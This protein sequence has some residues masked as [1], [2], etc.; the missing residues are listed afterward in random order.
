MSYLIRI[1]DITAVHYHNGKSSEVL[2]F[3][4]NEGPLS[5]VIVPEKGEAL[6]KRLKR[7]IER[8]MKSYELFQH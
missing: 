7:A 6:Q 2:L 1:G 8:V 4:E 5:R 3:R